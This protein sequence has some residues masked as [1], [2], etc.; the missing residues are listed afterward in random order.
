MC[1]SIYTST[2]YHYHPLK[3]TWREGGINWEGSVD[4]YTLPCVKHTASGKL[5]HSTRSSAQCSVMTLRGGIGGRGGKHKRE[6]ISV[7][8]WLIHFAVQQKLT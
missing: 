7:Y 6:G 1:D 4:I 2:F 8:I 3:I 5:L